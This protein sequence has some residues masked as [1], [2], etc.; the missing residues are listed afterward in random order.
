MFLGFVRRIPWRVLLVVGSPLFRSWAAMPTDGSGGPH[1]EQGPRA[2]GV[3]SVVTLVQHVG[4][5]D[6]GATGRAAVCRGESGQARGI[7][8]RESFQFFPELATSEYSTANMTSV[9]HTFQCGK[10]RKGTTSGQTRS[11]AHFRAF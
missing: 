8:T 5:S 6:T 1:A 7:A 11:E 4:R 2:G 10:L 3:G 9:R